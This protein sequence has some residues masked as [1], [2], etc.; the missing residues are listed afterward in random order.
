MTTTEDI[1]R[2]FCHS[3]RLQFEKVEENVYNVDQYRLYCPGSN[4][5]VDEALT[6]FQVWRCITIP[7]VH[8]LRNGDP[9]YPD[10]Y[11]E[12]EVSRHPTLLSALEKIGH[13]VVT[14]HINDEAMAEAMGDYDGIEDPSVGIVQGV[15]P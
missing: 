11:D 8:T 14:D 13:L 1:I 15:D 12:Q 10:D 4:S 9:G 2:P 6:D 7:G 3:F 5:V